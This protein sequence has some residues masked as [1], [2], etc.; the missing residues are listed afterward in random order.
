MGERPTGQKLKLNKIDVAEAQLKA[1]VRMFFEGGH[2]VPVYTLANA[3]RE[4]VEKIG[5]LIDVETAHRMLEAKDEKAVAKLKKEFN[6]IAAFFKHANHDARD[7][8]ELNETYVEVCLELACND[9]HRVTGGRPIEAQVYEAWVNAVT[10]GR[11][12]DVPLRNQHL[13]RRAVELFPGVREMSTRAE[14]K[15][16]GLQVMERSL[17][18]PSLVMEIRREVPPP[19]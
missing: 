10:F 17:R 4:I 12:S 7:T 2:P 16:I 9:F 3:V 8:I 13:V 15:T 6:R 1:A 14:Q 19:G 18:D 5:E 11:I